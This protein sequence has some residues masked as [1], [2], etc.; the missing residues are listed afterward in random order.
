MST[1]HFHS[2]HLVREL[3]LHNAPSVAA[4]SG[5]STGRPHPRDVSALSLTPH[6]LSVTLRRAPD[7]RRRDLQ[8]TA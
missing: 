4:E 5:E 8:Q 2:S 7:R 1:I 3:R 6:P